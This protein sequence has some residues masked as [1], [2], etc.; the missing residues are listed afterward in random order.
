VPE[1][2]QQFCNDAFKI[3]NGNL[4]DQAGNIWELTIARF[5]ASL[6]PL[7]EKMAPFLNFHSYS[8]LPRLFDDDATD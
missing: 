8:A 6:E 2:L 5:E 4:H 1:L 7:R 3:V